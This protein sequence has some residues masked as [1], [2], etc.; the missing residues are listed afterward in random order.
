M[1]LQ[2]STMRI[3]NQFAWKENESIP[4][5]PESAHER[6]ARPSQFRCVL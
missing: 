2:K 1:K 6:T 5:A 3:S 4:K